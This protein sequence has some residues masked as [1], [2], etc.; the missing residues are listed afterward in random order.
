[1]APAFR[2]GSSYS[3]VAGAV[4]GL[5]TLFADFDATGR[6]PCGGLGS[7]HWPSGAEARVVGG[8]SGTAEAVPFHEAFYEIVPLTPVHGENSLRLARR[9][10]RMQ[11]SFASLRMTR[12]GTLGLDLP[13]LA[14]QWDGPPTFRWRSPY[15]CVAGDAVC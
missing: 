13:P 1:M 10:G 12:L 8:A 3:A 7:G 11:R 2:R 14:S 5:W 6:L 15:S 4:S 9:G